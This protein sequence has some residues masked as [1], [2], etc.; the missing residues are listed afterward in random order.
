MN[1]ISTS[2]CYCCQSRGNEG[3]RPRSWS[4]RQEIPFIRDPLAAMRRPCCCSL[5][6]QAGKYSG[7]CPSLAGGKRGNSASPEKSTHGLPALQHQ[8]QTPVRITGRAEQRRT[9]PLA[10]QNVRWLCEE[11]LLFWNHNVTLL[12]HKLCTNGLRVDHFSPC[13]F[14]NWTLFLSSLCSTSC[15]QRCEYPHRAV[16]YHLPHT[17]LPSAW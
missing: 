16:K 5:A 15:G 12:P 6:R 11:W 13:I 14:H 2:H 17:F 1:S 3:P 9:K 10:F 8:F 4:E 7:S